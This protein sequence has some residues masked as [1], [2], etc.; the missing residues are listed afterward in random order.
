MLSMS[1]TSNPFRV[2]L[3]D[4]ERYRSIPP[5][6]MCAALALLRAL[7][8]RLAIRARIAQIRWNTEKYGE[9]LHNPLRG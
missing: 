6:F 5:N 9:I 7:R 1:V 4:V 8:V 3:G 2:W